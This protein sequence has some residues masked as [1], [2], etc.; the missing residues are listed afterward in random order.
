MRANSVGPGVFLEDSAGEKTGTGFRVGVK[1]G[2]GK[3]VLEDTSF[4]PMRKNGQ[5]PLGGL[6]TGQSER[7]ARIDNMIPLCLI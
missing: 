6:P 5:Q 3:S 7:R 2:G 4:I 1:W